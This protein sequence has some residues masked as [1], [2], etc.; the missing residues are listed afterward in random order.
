MNIEFTNRNIKKLSSLKSNVRETMQIAILEKYVDGAVVQSDSNLINL[1]ESR[2]LFKDYFVKNMGI[3]SV[4]FDNTIPCLE[5]IY[6]SG[7]IENPYLKNISLPHLVFN[8]LKLEQASYQTHEFAII[9]EPTQSHDLKRNFH[10]GVFDGP[11]L[12]YVL[13]NKYFVWM[14]I[15]PMEINTMVKPIND[16]S[17]SVL[18]LGGGLAYYPYMTSLK[19][20]VT[21]ITIV[22]NNPN[23]Y[24]IIKNYILPQFPNNKCKILLDDAKLYLEKNDLSFYDTIFFDIWADNISGA[25]YYKDFVKYELK[26]PNIKFKYWLEDSILDTF[27]VNISEYFDVK[28]GTE[29][30]QEC[31]KRIAPDLWNYMESIDDTIKRPDQFDYYLTKKFAKTYLLGQ[32]LT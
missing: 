26:Y 7:L 30:S 20:S 21:D 28:L 19:D 29:D 24:E 17:G 4:A 5:P 22:E 25:E 10:I 27:V 18:V 11:A 16:A 15:C 6:S 2:E 14:S 32:E 31:F 12:T 3:S 8:D 9:N 13:K 1:R 23:V